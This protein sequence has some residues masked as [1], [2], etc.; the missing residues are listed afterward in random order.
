M[1]IRKN[2][3]K[4]KRQ[5]IVEVSTSLICALHVFSLLSDTIYLNSFPKPVRLHANGKEVV[6]SG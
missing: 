3:V 2:A 6:V 1:N 5:R 4:E